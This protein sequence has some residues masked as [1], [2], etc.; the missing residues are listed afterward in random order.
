ML[1]KLALTFETEDEILKSEIQ[2]RVTEH[3]FL[4]VLFIM[5]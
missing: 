1:Y 4:V 3:C 2:M 5:L